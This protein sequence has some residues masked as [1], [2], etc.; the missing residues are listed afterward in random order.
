MFVVWWAYIVLFML[1]HKMYKFTEVLGQHFTVDF[2]Y[3]TLQSCCLHVDI[4]KNIQ[5]P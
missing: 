4:C 2:L 3:V 1:N 5:Q